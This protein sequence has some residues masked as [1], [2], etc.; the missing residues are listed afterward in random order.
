M[1][2]QIKYALEHFKGEPKVSTAEHVRNDTIR[3]FTP[4][5]PDVLAVLSTAETLSS[6]IAHQYHAEEPE[7]D[8]GGSQKHQ[9]AQRKEEPNQRNEQADAQ[10]NGQR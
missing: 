2:W 6:E 9:P 7:M 3:I 5:Q 8:G 10:Q 1:N 4:N